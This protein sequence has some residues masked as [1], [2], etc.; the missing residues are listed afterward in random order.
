MHGDRVEAGRARV[1]GR[2]EAAVADPDL[3]VASV[4]PTDS[5]GTLDPEALGAAV[6]SGSLDAQCSAPRICPSWKRPAIRF[7]GAVNA[8]A[9]P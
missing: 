4:Y 1:R 6:R 3:I 5:E 8:E 2:A 7:A 9:W